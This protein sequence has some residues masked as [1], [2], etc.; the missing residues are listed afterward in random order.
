MYDLVF[1]FG[2]NLKVMYTYF[3]DDSELKWHNTGVVVTYSMY[4]GTKIKHTETIVKAVLFNL[5]CK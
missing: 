4:V 1:I 2:Y 3:Y 5:Y